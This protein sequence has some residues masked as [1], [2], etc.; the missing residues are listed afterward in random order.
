MVILLK[1]SILGGDPLARPAD[2]YFIKEIQLGILFA[3]RFI[4]KKSCS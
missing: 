1:R 4:K 2:G 3:G